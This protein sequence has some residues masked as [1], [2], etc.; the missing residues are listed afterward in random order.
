MKQAD[1][2]LY[3]YHNSFQGFVEPLWNLQEL[4]ELSR[5]G[6]MPVKDWNT[7]CSSN[8]LNKKSLCTLQYTN[9]VLERNVQIN[10]LKNGF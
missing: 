6:W 2:S 8:G 10:H 5:C 1:G 4:Q 9:L 3:Y 7:L